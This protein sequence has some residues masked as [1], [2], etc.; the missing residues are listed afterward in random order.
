[1][2]KEII[3]KHARCFK[4]LSFGLGLGAFY[5]LFVVA[6]PWIALD[7]P[8][9][10]TTVFWTLIKGLLAYGLIC[11]YQNSKE[12][13]MALAGILMLASALFT[14]FPVQTFMVLAIEALAMTSLSLVLF[15]LNK[16]FPGL[17]LSVP[18]GLIFLGIIFSILNNPMMHSL[19]GFAWLY[20]FLVASSRVN[21]LSHLKPAKA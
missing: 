9:A 5:A 21:V 11:L 16:A 4:V 6:S 12:L 13:K 10:V 19:A 7:L 17:K 20:G 14:P 1:M 3:S 15:D 2:K 8:M 18:A